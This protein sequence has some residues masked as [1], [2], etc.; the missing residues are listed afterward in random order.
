MEYVDGDSSGKTVKD[1]ISICICTFHRNIML[2]RLLRKLK[3]Q[4]TG[5]LF[6]FSVV[7]VDN[8]ASGPAKETIMCLRA[9]LGLE[10][11]YEIEPENTIP[12]A[13]NR[14]LGLAHGNY[15]AI[16]DD[17]EFPPS[18]WLITMFKGI[19]TFDVDGVLGPVHPFF[20]KKPPAWLIKGRFCERQVYRTGTLL[21]WNQTRTGNVLL[22]KDVFDK[23]QLR[24]DLDRKTSS[25]DRAFFKQAMQA[26]YRFVAIEE[27]PVYEAVPPERWTKKYYL[28]RG[29][30][31]GFNAHRNSIGDMRGFARVAAPAKSTAALFAY[32]MLFPFSACLGSHMMVKCLES[33]GYHL[34]RLLAM[35]GIEIVKKRGF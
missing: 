33:G 18:H 20:D 7:V 17:D 11:E 28:T 9:E 16:I 12:A 27:A 29:L 22:K 3:L 13:R 15:V 30:V 10:V 5:G 8:D 4:E 25:S 32:A 2:D 35:M 21:E 23:H 26:G 24:F 1:H 6:N 19:Q 34:S 14:A 31:H